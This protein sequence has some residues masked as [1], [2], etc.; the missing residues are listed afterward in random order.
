MASPRTG[1]EPARA[2]KADVILAGG[3]RHRDFTDR[4]HHRARGRARVLPRGARPGPGRRLSPQ[5]PD[6]LRR[7]A[8]RSCPTVAGSPRTCPVSGARARVATSGTR[9]PIRWAFLGTLLDHATAGEPVALAGHGW[10]GA[11]ALAYAQ[12]HPPRVDALVLIDALPLLGASRGLGIA[13]QALRPGIGEFLM[14]RSPAAGSAVRCG[15]GPLTPPRGAM[16][17]SS[18]SGTTST[19]GPSGRSCGVGSLDQSRRA[20]PCRSRSW[21]R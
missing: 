18:P 3:L 7:L 17:G 12:R 2:H 9:S 6:E 14:G 21:P 8:R 10:G 5:P 13:R 20:D 19:R 16:S 4:A 15:P 1:F 11:L